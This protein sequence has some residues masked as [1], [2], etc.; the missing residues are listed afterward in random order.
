MKR[1]GHAI[2]TLRDVQKGQKQDEKG[3]NDS[4]RDTM[5]KI[6]TQDISRDTKRDAGCSGGT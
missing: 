1:R 2:I 5:D 4:K 6:G 3:H